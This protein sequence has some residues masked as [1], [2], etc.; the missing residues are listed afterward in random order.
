MVRRHKK[1]EQVAC[2]FNFSEESQKIRTVLDQGVWQKALDSSSAEWNGPGSLAPE[3]IR[4]TG[5]EVF[6]DY[7][8]LE[9][10]P[11]SEFRI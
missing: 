10:G 4:S 7:E 1:K 6:F 3:S 8:A 9:F 2:F 5:S 11:L